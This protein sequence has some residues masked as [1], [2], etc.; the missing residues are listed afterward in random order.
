MSSTPSK[1][2]INYQDNL[3]KACND[4]M[5]WMFLYVKRKVG[6]TINAILCWKNEKWGIRKLKQLWSDFLIKSSTKFTGCKRILDSIKKTNKF[7]PFNKSIQETLLS[8]YSGWICPESTGNILLKSFSRYKYETDYVE[9]H[10]L[11]IVTYVL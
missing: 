4:V 5:R 6:F 9:F 7:P 10:I 11:S 3:L 1:Y 2:D 8:T